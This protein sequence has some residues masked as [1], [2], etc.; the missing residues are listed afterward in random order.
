MDSMDD[1]PSVEISV[2]NTPTNS[3]EESVVSN[4]EESDYEEKGS[5]DGSDAEL[6]EVDDDDS[7]EES[8]SLNED[9]E[10]EG[11]PSVS[12]TETEIKPVSIDVNEI[13]QSAIGDDDDVEGED[14]MSDSDSDDEDAY[15]KFDESMKQNIIEQYH[16]DLKQI[17]YDE[18]SALTKVIRDENGNVID[19]IHK[20][21]PFL[22]K[23]ERARVLGLRAKQIN[24]GAEPFIEVPDYVIE[25]HVIAELELE[26]KAIPFIISRP[27]PNGKKEYW[28]LQDLELIDY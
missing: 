22:T 25:G 2:D 20:T 23:F 4:G 6:S 21:V 8:I 19:A 15:K 26:K 28:K 9:G 24:N 17:N 10:E 1:T 18:I 3:D 16:M 13:L 7:D 5:L 12:P 11:L 14:S 27:L